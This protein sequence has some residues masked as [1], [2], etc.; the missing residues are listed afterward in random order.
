MG[1][2]KTLQLIALIASTSFRTEERLRKSGVPVPQ[3]SKRVSYATLIVCPLSV[4]SNWQEQIQNHVKPGQLSLYLYHG[5]QR[6]R[7][8]THLLS[9]DVVLTTYNI[10]ATEYKDE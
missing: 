6:D 7:D 8:L 9:F 2:G 4:L 10:M 5:P 1:L 3:S